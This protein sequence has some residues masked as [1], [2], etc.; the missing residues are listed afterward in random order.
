MGPRYELHQRIYLGGL[1]KRCSKLVVRKMSC[2]T[3]AVSV[4]EF[5]MLHLT[6]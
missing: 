3:K 6:E 1:F 5:V 4:S 2:K